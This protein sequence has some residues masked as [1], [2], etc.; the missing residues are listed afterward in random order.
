VGESRSAPGTEHFQVVIRGECVALLRTVFDEPSIDTRQ[1]NSV[2]SID[3]KDSSHL[4]GILD[5]LRDLP[6]EVVSVGRFPDDKN[7]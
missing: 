3:V 5:R 7:E 2:L 6:V 4:W 1:G